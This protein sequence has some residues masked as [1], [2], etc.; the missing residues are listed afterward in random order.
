[1]TKRDDTMNI[2]DK[3][4]SDR[5]MA[6]ITKIIISAYL[7]GDTDR[8]LGGLGSCRDG[9][10]INGIEI[11]LSLGVSNLLVLGKLRSSTLFLVVL[12]CKLTL[13][14]NE[15]VSFSTEP[16]LFSKVIL[17]LSS[18]FFCI[19]FHELLALL[20]K[21]FLCVWRGREGGSVLENSGMLESA[22]ELPVEDSVIDRSWLILGKMGLVFGA[23]RQFW[24]KT[25]TATEESGVSGNKTGEVIEASWG[26]D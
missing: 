2:L 11:F 25:G 5:G 19:T 18:K 14:A 20:G 3:F 7:A 8:P 12:L 10:L 17:G 22:V 15:E 26:S 9:D 4:F 1:M 13:E 23:L 6:N 24:G 21:V 16:K